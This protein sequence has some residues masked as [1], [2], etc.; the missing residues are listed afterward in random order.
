MGEPSRQSDRAGAL[1]IT[2][3][4]TK[5]LVDFRSNRATGL[6]E[7][8]MADSLL[9]QVCAACGQPGSVANHLRFL[10]PLPRFFWQVLIGIPALFVVWILI[11]PL[12][13]G[14]AL[15]HALDAGAA[16]AALAGGAIGLWVAQ[17][18]FR[19]TRNVMTFYLCDRHAAGYRKLEIRRKI[20]KGVLLVVFVLTLFWGPAAILLVFLGE[21][22]AGWMIRAAF[23]GTPS[24]LLLGMIC[25]YLVVRRRVRDY[26]GFVP[27]LSPRELELVLA[28]RRREFA[29]AVRA[30]CSSD[31]AEEAGA[32]PDDGADQSR[33]P[34][35]QCGRMNLNWIEQCPACKTR[36]R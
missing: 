2:I 33:E 29:E 18:A 4:I 8:V 1:F 6:P 20:A 3:K 5:S 17:G 34:C 16:A 24:A 9:P 35:P 25:V 11:T 22:P 30:H 14:E 10:G 12:V 15:G 21:G 7:M 31:A 32:P 36:L 26:R 27:R 28:C 19:R 13:R 23:A